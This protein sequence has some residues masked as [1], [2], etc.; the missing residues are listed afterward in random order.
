MQKIRLQ[1]LLLGIFLFNFASAQVAGISYTLAPSAEYVWWNDKAGIEDGLLWGGKIG[2]GFGEF[3]ELR[4]SYLQS[5]NLQNDFKDFGLRNFDENTFTKTDVNVRRYGGEVKANFSRGRLLPFILLGTGIQEIQL[6]DLD[7]RKQIYLTAG[8]GIKVGIANRFTMTLEARNTAYRYNTGANL[9][10]KDDQ[11]ALGETNTAFPIEELTNWSA[12]AALQFYIGGRKPGQM[13]ELDRAYFDAFTGGSGGFNLGLEAVAG[14][15]DFDKNLLFRDTWMAG[16]SAGFD[17]GPYVGLRGFYW[18]AMQEDE[19]TKFDD[20]AMWG[21]ELRMQLNSGGGM[22]PFL[23][24]GGGKMDVLE[25]YE[26]RKLVESDTVGIALTDRNDTG[27]AMGGAGLLIPITS[28]FKIF[29]SARAILTSTSPVEDLSAPEEI[30]TSWFYS[31]GIKLNFGKK[32]KSP[33]A[34]MRNQIT[35]ALDIQKAENDAKTETL[36]LDYEKKVVD[37][38]NQLLEAYAEKDFEKAEIIKEE[39]A[40]A[41]QVVVELENIDEVPAAPVTI[42]NNLPTVTPNNNQSRLPG[43]ENISL[44]PSGSEIKMTPAEFENLIEEILE[45][46]EGQSQMHT[47]HQPAYQT[48]GASQEYMPTNTSNELNQLM[49]RL[50]AIEQHVGMTAKT[51]VPATATD[52]KIL[53]MLTKLEKRLSDNKEEVSKINARLDLLEAEKKVADE[54]EEAVETFQLFKKKSRKERRKERKEA[55]EKKSEN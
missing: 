19:L 37:L 8:A 25:G 36:K 16:A 39:K 4:G 18:R 21:G 7:E 53:E 3:F 12:A 14:K 54:T 28:N 33:E 13:T 26:G 32:D 40:Q 15:M 6:G 22:V 11:I 55:K 45:G 31:A 1:L 41:E 52:A 9:L 20:L 34:I 10:T 49:S 27:F 24:L 17:F 29:G 5:L 30:N 38:E 47:I 43:M 44:V 48:Y 35:D 42:N 46:V 50:D 23:L 2:L 51:D